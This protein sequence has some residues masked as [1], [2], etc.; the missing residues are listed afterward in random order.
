MPSCGKQGANSLRGTRDTQS[1]KNARNVTMGDE[2]IHTTSAQSFHIVGKIWSEMRM[3]F[4][5]IEMTD[6]WDDD[7]LRWFSLD[8]CIQTGF[9]STRSR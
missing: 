3:I 4:E 2:V 8:D 5:M 1:P 6:D 7:F 9:N